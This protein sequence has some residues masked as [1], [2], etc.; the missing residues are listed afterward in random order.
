M[1][2]HRKY[3]NAKKRIIVIIVTGHCIIIFN[4]FP[5]DR[6]YQ[7]ETA[8]GGLTK[9]GDSARPSWDDPR[10]VMKLGISQQHQA[11]DFAGRSF[12]RKLNPQHMAASCK[13]YCNSHRNSLRKAGL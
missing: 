3:F 4:I 7:W 2:V 12:N 5:R 11:G 8:L 6:I 10:A 1:D 9:Q 13:L